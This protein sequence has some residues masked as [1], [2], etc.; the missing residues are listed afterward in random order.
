MMI[1]RASDIACAFVSFTDTESSNNNVSESVSHWVLILLD[2]ITLLFSA[3][4]SLVR[5]RMFYQQSCPH[6]CYAQV[7]D[8]L[9]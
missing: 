6:H 5:G 8:F 2:K 3:L 4:A 1:K 9:S 7:E